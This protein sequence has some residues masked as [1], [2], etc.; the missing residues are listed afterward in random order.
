MINLYNEILYN[1]KNGDID[2]PVLQEH[3]KKT[4]D[5]D[6]CVYL[7]DVLIKDIESHT[8]QYNDFLSNIVFHSCTDFIAY[9]AFN[10][11]IIE[12]KGTV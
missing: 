10:R 8:A 2:Y 6:L 7:N 1:I 11:L 9:E 12:K 4:E 3:I 5:L